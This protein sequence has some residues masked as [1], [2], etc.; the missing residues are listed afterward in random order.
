MKPLN[1]ILT[2]KFLE[3]QFDLKKSSDDISIEFKITKPLIKKY[4]KLY[5]IIEYFKCKIC[6]TDINLFKINK[7]GKI[8]THNMCCSCKK[9]SFSRTYREPGK[10]ADKSKQT[11]LKRYGKFNPFVNVVK[12]K[13]TSLARYGVSC[14]LLK[15]GRRR[16]SKIS[17]ELFWSVYNQLLEEL[18]DLTCFAEECGE[19]SF[20]NAINN[21]NYSLDFFIFDINFAIEFN[22]NY[23]HCL[24]FSKEEMHLRPFKFNQNVTV[25]DVWDK[26]E[27]RDNIFNQLGI[28]CFNII[29]SE[30]LKDKQFWVDYIVEEINELYNYKK[31]IGEIK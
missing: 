19:F 6:G 21:K 7:K 3:E 2:K 9:E 30:Y 25:K 15:G 26:D 23:W 31:Q 4:I 12:I 10:G 1:K 27:E 24:N 17:Q 11:R 29:Q 13:E 16:Y 14:T 28:Y 18:K 20:I 22:G 5:D 8:C